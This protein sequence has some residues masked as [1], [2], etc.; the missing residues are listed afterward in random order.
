MPIQGNQYHMEVLQKR[1]HHKS[2]QAAEG[3]RSYQHT[4]T[5]GPMGGPLGLRL[6][7]ANT[8]FKYYLL[9]GS[10]NYSLVTLFIQGTKAET[11]V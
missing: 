5:S 1:P 11:L 7:V 3:P 8:F 6:K 4:G 9:E 2:S 10:T